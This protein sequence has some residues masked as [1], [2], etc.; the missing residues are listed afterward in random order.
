MVTISVDCYDAGAYAVAP[1]VTA[2]VDGP[3]RLRITQDG[4]LATVSADPPLSSARVY[5]HWWIDGEYSHVTADPSH[6]LRLDVGEQV[7]ID[8]WATTDPDFD[9]ASASI[10]AFPQRRVVEW[11]D[12]EDDATDYYVLQTTTV[13]TPAETDWLTSSVV[14]HDGRWAYNAATEP[15]D[16]DSQYSFRVLPVSIAGNSG[17]P[18]EFGPELFVR[19]PDAPAF[20]A[21]LNPGTLKVTFDLE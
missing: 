16:D 18:T 2:D 15:L 12:T 20:S 10:A 7:Q 17:T 5:Y 9:P 1:S 13:A 6:S 21:T 14:R 3:L 19:R 4:R 11:F 8:L